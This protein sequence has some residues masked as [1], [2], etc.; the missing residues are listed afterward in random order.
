MKVLN[1]RPFFNNIANYY[2]NNIAGCPRYDP[3]FYPELYTW[4]EREYDAKIHP[5]IG[6]WRGGGQITFIDDKNVALFILK[7][8]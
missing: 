8:S 6:Y 1:V 3:D 4:L 7:W 5:P 2:I